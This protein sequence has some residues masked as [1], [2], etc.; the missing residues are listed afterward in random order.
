MK[1]GGYLMSNICFCTSMI[2]ILQ[3][4]YVPRGTGTYK[5][6]REL[7]CIRHFIQY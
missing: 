5:R 2:Y 3:C 7:S 4:S 6:K 1:I